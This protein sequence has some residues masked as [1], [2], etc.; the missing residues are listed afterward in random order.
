MVDR[1]CLDSL[2]WH[3]LSVQRKPL[4]TRYTYYQV[5][6]HGTVDLFNRLP[7]QMSAADDRYSGV[8]KSR[9]SD[10]H[11]PFATR[12]ISNPLMIRPLIWKIASYAPMATASALSPKMAAVVN[13][14]ARPPRSKETKSSP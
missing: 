12:I 10:E 4:H 6:D 2:Q 3:M 1:A 8:F 13:V 11:P 14:A 5:R 9:G 7:Q